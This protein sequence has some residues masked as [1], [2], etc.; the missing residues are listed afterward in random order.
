M[1]M[2]KELC[3]ECESEDIEY[4][5]DDDGALCQDCYDRFEPYEKEKLRW[6]K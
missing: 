4:R 1:K 3:D 2:Y 6:H 5:D